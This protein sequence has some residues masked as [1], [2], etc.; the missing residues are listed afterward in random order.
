MTE[1]QARELLLLQ[2]FEQA[3]DPSWSTA[4][5]AW[6]T[7]EARRIEGSTAAAETL[8]VRRVRLAAQRLVQRQ[9]ALARWFDGFALPGWSL[10]AALAAAFALG[11][12]LD[13]FGGQGRVNILA[14]PLL[15][16]LAWNL[17]VYGLLAVQALRTTSASSAS[18]GLRDSLARGVMAIAQRASGVPRK[19]PALSR[20][21][22]DW[23][24]VA[25]P[26][27]TARAATALHALAAMAALGLIAGL[28]SRGL[29]LEYRAGWESTFLGASGVHT[30]VSAL[31]G[32]AA[33]LIG[34]PL[35]TP[36][37]V[38]ALNF[39]A[40]R[41]ENAAPWIHRIA[42]TVVLFVVLPRLVLAAWGLR[43]S[44]QLAHALPLDLHAPYF[45]KLV[46]EL[47][48]Q[49]VAL[50]V[51]P[52]AHRLEPERA[53]RLRAQ[54]GE[55]LGVEPDASIDPPLA[56]GDETPA[57]AAA[58]VASRRRVALFSASATPEAEVQGAFARSLPADAIV[59]VDETE[60]RQRFTGPD[61]APRLEQRRLAWRAMLEPQGRQPV[62]IDLDG[63]ASPEL[64]EALHTP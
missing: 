29:T 51:Q 2:S 5:A 34:D 47:T 26:L 19:W 23:A 38:A 48:G 8:L 42:L 16:L 40:G 64:I 60:L 61:A 58:E 31:L 30:L 3:S 59:L 18:H 33:A 45:V 63:A 20:F 11:L 24:A 41:G 14:L 13:S 25:R 15:G 57:V 53:L 28:Y 36:E 9:P 44:R 52:Y 12:A 55:A 1:S 46:R 17:V 56:Y 49:R 37:A 4:D 62:F 6:A 21:G 27:H 22:L 7:A 50:R 10:P 35:P 32:P 54:L 43:R 39:A